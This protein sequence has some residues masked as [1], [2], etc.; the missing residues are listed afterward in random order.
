MARRGP[1]PEPASVKLA[2]GNPGRRPVG[3]DPVIIDDSGGSVSPPAW[4]KGDGLIIWQRIAPRLVAMKLLGPLDAEPFGRYCQ[5]FARWV[6]MQ[7]I[8]DKGEFYESESQHGKLKRIEPAFTIADRLE[9][10]LAA[11]EDRFG[12]N[13]SERQR[14]FAARAAAGAPGDLFDR[15]PSGDKTAAKP[16]EQPA[17]DAPKPRSAIGYLQ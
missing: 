12:L 7:K 10:H 16:G 13:P 5:N 2:K 9:K 1:K 6:K 8:L 17:A 3:A 14:I 11:A 4:L 15:H